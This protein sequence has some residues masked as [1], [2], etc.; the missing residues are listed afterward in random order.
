MLLRRS[1]GLPTPWRALPVWWNMTTWFTWRTERNWTS[2]W[3]YP[4]SPAL[5]LIWPGW[6]EELCLSGPF[7]EYWLRVFFSSVIKKTKQTEFFNGTSLGIFL[8]I[9]PCLVFSL[10]PRVMSDYL[11]QLD[12]EAARELQHKLYSDIFL[13]SINS[14][15]AEK[16][17]N[18]GAGCSLAS[19]GPSTGPVSH[20]RW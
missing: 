8:V 1:S 2:S 16:Y 15:S 13:F 19:G 14:E 4:T 6:G 11:G 9:K 7:L 12:C 10:S 18:R 20:E 3:K 5:V 17:F